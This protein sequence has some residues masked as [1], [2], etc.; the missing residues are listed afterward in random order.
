MNLSGLIQ[1][2]RNILIGFNIT[3]VALLSESYMNT[4]KEIVEQGPL[5][6]IFSIFSLEVGPDDG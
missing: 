4:V 3:L 2:A 5:Y 6:R 1:P